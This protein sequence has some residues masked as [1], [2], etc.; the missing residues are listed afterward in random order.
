MTQS[1]VFMFSGQG[2]HYYHMGRELYVNV[3][4]FREKIN[5]FDKTAV[6]VFGHS[7]L[8]CMYNPDKKKSEIF[9]QTEITSP[10]IIMIE[11]ALAGFLMDHGIVPDYLLGASL[12]EFTSLIVSG[13]RTLYET[14]EE[15]KERLKLFK[16][17]CEPGKMI[18]IMSSPELYETTPLLHKNSDIA[19]VNFDHHFVLSINDNA[20]EKITTYLSRKGIVHQLLGVSQGFHSRLIDPVKFRYLASTKHLL[21][22]PAKISLI[23]C[24]ETREVSTFSGDYLWRVLRKPILF[25]TTIEHFKRNHKNSLYIDLG[26]SGTLATFVKYNLKHEGNPMIFPIMTF[27]GPDIKNLEKLM[28]FFFHK[29]KRKNKKL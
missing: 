23:S 28:R 29:E 2:S 17:G 5:E 20:A 16:E 9:D 24:A 26:P 11:C 8:S 12:G 27:L 25:Q 10:A 19:A 18:G 22:R 4:A 14:F 7:I 3:P 1:I 13:V 15:I 6:K 21:F